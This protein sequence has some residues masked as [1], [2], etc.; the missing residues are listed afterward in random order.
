VLRVSGGPSGNANRIS[1][2]RIYI[3]RLQ[4]HCS[5]R[6]GQTSMNLGDS[7]VMVKN[8]DKTSRK[9]E[10]DAFAKILAGKLAPANHS[11]ARLNKT[12]QY[13]TTLFQ[14]GRVYMQIWLH[15]SM[16][17][18]ITDKS[19]D[20]LNDF[21]WQN[22]LSRMEISFQREHFLTHGLKNT[23][24]KNINGATRGLKNPAIGTDYLMAVIHIK[25]FRNQAG[26][27]AYKAATN[28]TDD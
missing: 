9:A 24:N 15:Q 5:S 18:L 1:V 23:G 4:S 11:F 6:I 21:K 14:P 17:Q 8:R 12:T 10:N 2:G 20:T 27:A 3:G 26:V 13:K 19:G 28:K 16:N 22:L 25:E 7:D